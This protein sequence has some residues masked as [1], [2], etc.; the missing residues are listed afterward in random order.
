MFNVETD[1]QTDWSQIH[2]AFL[3]RKQKLRYDAPI[4]KYF[5]SYFRGVYFVSVRTDLCLGL[6][7]DSEARAK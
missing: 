5:K 4:T 6:K 7:D 1:E 2:R 3:Q